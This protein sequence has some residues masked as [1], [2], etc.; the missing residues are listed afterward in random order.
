MKKWIALTFV[1]ACVL[2]L[3]GC[4]KEQKLFDITGAASIHLRSGLTGDYVDV[5]DV[6]DI[7]YITDNING[8]VFEKG[9]SHK[10]E[11]GYAYALRW[12][13]ADKTLIADLYVM[14]E[15]TVV[16]EERYYN[17]MEV[18]HE[19]DTEYFAQLLEEKYKEAM[20]DAPED[21]WGVTLTAVDV[22]PGGLTLVITHSGEAPGGQLQTG[23]P[24]WLEVWKDGVWNLVPELPVE[25]G[26]ARAWTMEAYL[27]PINGSYEREV[28][29]E[30]IYGELPVG[31]YRI[32]KEIML[33]RGTGDYD[34]QT[35]YAEFEIQ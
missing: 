9:K 10:G 24:Y 1:L 11:N 25:D 19:I 8:L 5:A 29:F 15:Y 14:D 33:F 12:Y 6:E 7:K 17:A 3:A 22:T 30:W 31:T 28:H 18:D 35:Y 26:V 21:T 20:P 27:I 34:E 32:G 13:D 16:F 4:K 2:T 23:S